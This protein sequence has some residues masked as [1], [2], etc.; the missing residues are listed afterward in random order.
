MINELCFKL[1]MVMLRGGLGAQGNWDGPG[2]YCCAPS[3]IAYHLREANE[4]IDA[5]PISD[6]CSQTSRTRVCFRTLS[7]MIKN[8]HDVYTTHAVNITD[9][10]E[11]DLLLT[12]AKYSRR[13]E[14]DWD[15]AHLYRQVIAKGDLNHRG[16]HAQ[17]G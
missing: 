17:L 12:R 2:S 3:R 7:S 15:F 16:S 14:A 6:R 5:L 8:A 10:V 9:E 11:V 1:L 4:F 13:V